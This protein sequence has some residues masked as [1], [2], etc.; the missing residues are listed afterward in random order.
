MYT[1]REVQCSDVSGEKKEVREEKLYWVVYPQLL[2]AKNNEMSEE[3]MGLKS[4]K[5]RKMN[6]SGKEETTAMGK[7][8]IV[9]ITV[10]KWYS[11]IIQGIY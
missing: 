6:R 7:Q 5:E 8:S 1:A 10:L 11:C 3:T 4:Q 2:L 9:Q